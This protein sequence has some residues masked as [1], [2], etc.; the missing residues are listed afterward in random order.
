MA[1]CQAS[2]KTTLSR[3]AVEHFGAAHF[4][5]DDVYLTKAERRAL[6]AEV[7]PLFAVR[8]PP[9]THGLALARRTVETLR[10]AGPSDRTAI[11]AFDKLAD[12]RLPRPIGPCLRA[13]PR[14]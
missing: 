12:D 7:H 9:G 2:G 6:A 10:G 1:G 3:A 13:R 4:S 5:I 8:G 14:R 11:P